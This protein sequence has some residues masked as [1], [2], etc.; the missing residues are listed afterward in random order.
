MQK[1]AMLYCT[2]EANSKFQ[3]DLSK[4]RSCK[5]GIEA[6][7]KLFLMQSDVQ[8]VGRTIFGGQVDAI[9]VPTDNVIASNMTLV[10]H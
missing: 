5:Y 9:Y 8:S 10:M 3:I 6:I 4:R 1:V 7:E 2:G